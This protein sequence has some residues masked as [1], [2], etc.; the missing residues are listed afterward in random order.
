MWNSYQIQKQ[1][2]FV[3][4]TEARDYILIFCYRNYIKTVV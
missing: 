3:V 2:M 4:S 1:L